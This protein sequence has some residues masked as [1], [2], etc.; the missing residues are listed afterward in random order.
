M[1]VGMLEQ[2]AV[3]WLLVWIEGPT[4]RRREQFGGGCLEL[5]QFWMCR[6]VVAMLERYAFG[7]GMISM[8]LA[9]ASEAVSAWR[10]VDSANRCRD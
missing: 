8:L 7:C 10:R 5:P 9:M 3:G 2:W 4:S 6:V 1:G